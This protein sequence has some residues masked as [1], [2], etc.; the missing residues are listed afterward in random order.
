MFLEFLEMKSD[1]Q[2]KLK[3]IYIKNIMVVFFMVNAKDQ[4]SHLYKIMVHLFQMKSKVKGMIC[5]L[6]KIKLIK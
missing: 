1:I 4:A 2:M 3:I 6:I 5:N